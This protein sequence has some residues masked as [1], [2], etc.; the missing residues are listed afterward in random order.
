MKVIITGAKGQLGSDLMQ[1]LQADSRY[2][3][4]GYGKEEL[5]I[6]D[7]EQVGKVFMDVN[8]DIVIHAAAYT[9]VDAA[10]SEPDAAYGVNALG[11]RNIALAAE[12]LKSKLVY[13]STDYVFD[14]KATSPIHE[15]EQPCPDS[16]YGKSK[17]AG[18]QFVRDFHSKFFIVR[19]SWVYGKHGQNFVKT[20]LKLAKEQQQLKVVSDQTGSPTYSLDL[21]SIIVNLALTEKYGTYHISNSGSCS[22]YEFAKAIF[23]EADIDVIVEPCRTEDFPRPAPRPKYSVFDHMRLRLNGFP[24]I[25]NWREA[26]KDFLTTL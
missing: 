4:Y 17:L 19:T 10:E 20:M 6:T 5:D 3:V 2:E 24:E 11:T 21:A 9:K 18:E 15:F 1:L 13:V 23:E 25:R 14:G 8:P 22:W 16:V 26:L 12:K 7:M